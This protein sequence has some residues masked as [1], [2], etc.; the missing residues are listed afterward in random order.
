[1]AVSTEPY[2]KPPQGQLGIALDPGLVFFWAPSLLAQDISITYVDTVGE[3]R[4]KISELRMLWCLTCRPEYILTS[5][6]HLP[7]M[8]FRARCRSPADEL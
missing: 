4:P 6:P 1:M 3:T 2:L 8:G 5:L 7:L